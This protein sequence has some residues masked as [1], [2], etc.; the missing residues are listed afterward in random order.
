MNITN[1][2]IAFFLNRSAEGMQMGNVPTIDQQ[3]S[4]AYMNCLQWIA[5]GIFLGGLGLA[6]FGMAYWIR[7]FREGGGKIEIPFISSDKESVDTKDKSS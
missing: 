4:I 5:F 3:I 1:E 2:T 7:T 6:I